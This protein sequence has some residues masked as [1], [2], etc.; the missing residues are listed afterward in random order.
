MEPTF[1]ILI[2]TSGRADL[3]A[4]AVQS[5]REQTFRD[6]E[7]VIADLSGRDD[8]KAFA[9]QDPRIRYVFAPAGGLTTWDVAAKHARGKYM[10]W[11]DDDNYLLPFALELFQGE[12]DRTHADIIS[13]THFYYY[14]QAHPRHYLRNSIGVI[15]FTGAKR[16]VE[17]QKVLEGIYA[18]AR[19]GAGQDL[20][21]FHFSATV[22]AHG[23]I[24]RA[25][26]RLG[27]VLLA[28]VPNIHSLQPIMFAFAQSCACIDWPVVIVGRLG[29]SM[30]QIWSTAARERFRRK[31]FI[32]RLSPVSGYARINGILENYLRVQDLL[33]ERLGSL[34]VNYEHFALLYLRE[35]AYLD[36]DVAAAIRT[37]R[38][39]FA[40]LE[41][42]PDGARRALETESRRTALCWPILHIARRLGLHHVW[43]AVQGRAKNAHLRKRSPRERMQGTREFEIPIPENYRDV[44]IEDLGRNI[45][46]IILEATGRD[47][48]PPR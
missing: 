11:L 37:W 31:P 47:I 15:P 8:V 33:P 20:P 2:P 24:E 30:S 25:I 3:I 14:D 43:R 38:N 12:I 44:S 1:S 19:R 29:V 32:P 18:F 22:I 28:D 4:M 17:P 23:V 36:M 35:L 10:L 48:T 42:L 46:P 6:F 5:V 26:E 39:F 13:A 34:S 45:R 40:F 16:F 21:R 7:I 9:K 41:T 27:V